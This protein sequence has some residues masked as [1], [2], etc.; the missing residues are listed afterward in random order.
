MR[1]SL[2]GFVHPSEANREDIFILG[3]GYVID[4]VGFSAS[5]SSPSSLILLIVLETGA[6]Q[7]IDSA[8]CSHDF[9]GDCQPVKWLSRSRSRWALDRKGF[10]A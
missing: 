10:L 4:S 1:P 7:V 6:I 5:A 2:D 8:G 3:F 9:S